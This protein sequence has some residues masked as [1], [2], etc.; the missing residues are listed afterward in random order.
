M[1]DNLAIMGAY[2]IIEPSDGYFYF[3][4]IFYP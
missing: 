3:R 4:S 2:I 1:A